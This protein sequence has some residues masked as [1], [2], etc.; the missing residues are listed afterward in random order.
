M[1]QESP[2]P[3]LKEKLPGEGETRPSRLSQNANESFR[4]SNCQL[5]A[6]TCTVYQGTAKT[7]DKSLAIITGAISIIIGVR[8]SR[9]KYSMCSYIPSCLLTKKNQQVLYLVG[10]TFLN[11]QRSTLEPPP[12]EAFGWIHAYALQASSLL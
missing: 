2:P 3:I 11:S 12:P 10:V 9:K 6:Y 4:K 8:F 1:S 5:D 7:E